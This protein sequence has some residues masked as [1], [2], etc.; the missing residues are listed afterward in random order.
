LIFPEAEDIFDISQK[1]GLTPD[2]ILD[3]SADINPLGLSKKAEKKL[4]ANL[5][6]VLRYPDSHC[7]D[8]AKALAQFH[9]L[10]EDQILLGGGETAFIYALPRVLSMPRVLVVTPTFREFE[11]ALETANQ[12]GECRIDFFETREE[13]GF[14]VDAH[15][16]ISS[17]TIGYSA[18][19]LSNPGFPT[20]ILTGKEDL[21]R[22]LAQTERQKTWFILDERSIDFIEE[23]SLK[24]MVNT[25]PR[26]IILRS[27]AKFF[28]LPGLQ[29]G[30]TIANREV[31][32]ILRQH[33]DLWMVNALAQIA[34]IEALND[35]AYIRR[36][37]EWMPKERNRLIQ[38]LRSIPGFVPYPGTANYLLIQLLPFLGFTAGE[39]REKLISQ[40]IL[41]CDCGPFHHLG[42]YFLQI[43]V[44]THKENN[45]LIKALRQIVQN[46]PPSGETSAT[47]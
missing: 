31:V 26:L 43:A 20:G 4:K 2:Q 35:K 1:H 13:D 8:L 3:F 23:N 28:A 37:K 25:C 33:K 47:S 9:D 34:A 27:L 44:R 46:L 19:Y 15:G 30:Y 32:N 18:L 40:G 10:S 22:I 42:P 12:K 24:E 38:S 29:V 36:T 5:F 39:L 45:L 7:L 11:G 41:I 6:A 21:L 17:L 14:E 16:L